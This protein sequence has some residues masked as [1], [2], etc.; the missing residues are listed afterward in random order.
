M[1][2][3]FIPSSDLIGVFLFVLL[4]LAVFSQ[5]IQNPQPVPYVASP[6]VESEFPYK[7]KSLIYTPEELARAQKKI[8]TDPAARKLAREI[9]SIAERWAQWSDEDLMALIPD[10]SVPR[11]FDL[12]AGGCPVHGDTVFHVGGSY[13]W[14]LDPRKQFQVK[15]PVG[16]ETYPTNDFDP[17][18]A[19]A[20][21]QG[22][23]G[24]NPYVDNGW[25]W[26]AADGEK[27]WFV[28]YANQWFFNTYIKNAIRNLG[29]AYLLT[30]RPEFAHKALVM[31]HRLAEVYPGMDYEHQSRYG[32][33]QKQNGRHYPGKVLNRIW[34]TN[35]IQAA[36]ECYDAVWNYIPVDQKLMQLLQKDPIDIQAFIEVHLLEEAV[37]AFGQQKIQGNFGMHQL[38][39]LYVLLAR[40]HMDNETH[41][42]RIIHNV[43]GSLLQTGISYALYNYIFR[44]GVPME[45]PSYNF[46]WIRKLTALNDRLK[47]FGVNFFE[48]PRFQDILKSP[49][50]TMGSDLYTIDIGDSGSTTGGII[51]RDQNT[52]E[53]AFAN[54]GDTAYLSWLYP[55]KGQ[56][57]DFER[58]MTYESLFRPEIELA[59]LP[60]DTELGYLSS[61]LLAG[62]GLGKL[63]SGGQNPSTVALI[64][65]L[66]G[67]HY[68]WDF[69]NFELFAFG[70]KMMPDFGY[71]DAMNAYVSG[72][73][74]WS[75]NTVAHNTVVVDSRR[76]N[77]NLPGILHN[78]A[79]GDFA[80]TV[81]ASSPA[82]AQATR[83]RRN[84]FSVD[85]GQD[86]NYLVDFFYVSG[87]H[88]H[89]YILHGPPGYSE[90]KE[91]EWSSP[92]KGTYAGKEV[93]IGEL[94]D[95]P[96]MNQPDYS[97]GYGGY[98]GSGFQHL[99]HVQQKKGGAGIVEFEHVNDRR[100][101]LKLRVLEDRGQDVYLAD[102]YN[103][104]RSKEFLIKHVITRSEN[105]SGPLENTF[106]SVIEPYYENSFI[107][108]AQRLSIEGGPGSQVV[109]VERGGRT[110]I[111]ISDFEQIDKKVEGLPLRTDATA[112]VVTLDSQGELMR[113][114]FSDGRYLTYSDRTFEAAPLTGDVTEVDL[115]NRRVKVR[116]HE[117]FTEEEIKAMN[118]EV[119]FFQNGHLETA[120][121]IREFVLEGDELV[122][123]TMDDMLIGR[124]NVS[125][126]ADEPNTVQTNNYLRFSSTY[127]G[128]HLLNENYEK[129]GIVT[130]ISG[131]KLTY[132][133]AGAEIFREGTTAD[134]WISTLASGD[135]AEWKTLFQWEAEKEW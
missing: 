120:H 110:D 95:N 10:G 119:M 58:K 73:Y 11:S 51:G 3:R 77:Q 93:A 123:T 85:A 6:E 98:S 52:Y 78:F 18:V 104:P 16:H 15:C 99:F 33:M 56:S 59:T 8:E 26:T 113:V 17:S 83:Y 97:G 80:R 53:I 22:K 105:E 103:H 92:A 42:N 75:K 46:L 109:Q 2:H 31:L 90:V 1:A 124:V 12:N 102:A 84:L 20:P 70:Q 69:L 134:V 55:D 57:G 115:K 29:R 94:Y 108:N 131:N 64:Y 107:R 125:Q 5:R 121:P 35:F 72:V 28:A 49:I 117:S 7:T 45:S 14:I 39:L 106:S 19:G 96:H 89:D 68:H 9:I 114:F 74:T 37:K 111:V 47:Q 21:L 44:D 132:S 13:P 133:G 65:G 101:R 66:H 71:P 23:P 135:R 87:G 100:A 91:G 40:Q 128:A 54:T 38:A 129:V 30:E 25:G 60:D 127:I 61:R 27:Y 82:Y 24:E 67:S 86:R 116:V 34:E 43:S 126:L 118:T 63:A 32:Q 4:P 36:A 79:D 81:Q 112:A 130:G 48:D 76:Q 62:Y 41:I 50:Y 122:L 88:R